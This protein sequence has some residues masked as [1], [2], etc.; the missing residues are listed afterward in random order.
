MK[1]DQPD[2]TGGEPHVF[3]QTNGVVDLG[4]NGPDADDVT[5][6]KPDNRTVAGIA[7]LSTTRP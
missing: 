7:M 2:E 3:D 5:A 1:R 4:A 6:G